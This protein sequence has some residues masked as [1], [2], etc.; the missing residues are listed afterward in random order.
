MIHGLM[1]LQMS[2]VWRNLVLHLND[3]SQRVKSN[4][5]RME[6]ENWRTK[7]LRQLAC[8]HPTPPPPSPIMRPSTISIV[9]Q[10]RKTFHFSHVSRFP[11]LI[12]LVE[13]RVRKHVRTYSTGTRK[14]EGSTSFQT[15]ARSNSS[16]MR[17][18]SVWRR[19]F[20]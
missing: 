6:L 2:S 1:R 19:K 5:W 18:S 14:K 16:K 4:K 10:S 15:S 8:L 17:Q 7:A 9:S 12:G 3:F 20:S 11:G 13:P